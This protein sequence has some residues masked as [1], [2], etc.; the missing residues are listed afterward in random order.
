MA[1]STIN[2]AGLN[3]PLTLTSPVIDTITSAAA[4]ALTL[5]SAGTTAV[6]I[7]T[8]QNLLIGSTSTRASSKLDIRG[9]VMT[10]GSN[11]SYYAK[12]DYSAGTGLL[13]LAAESGG[14]TRFLG[15]TTE[16]MRIGS[17]GQVSIGTN[18][19]TTGFGGQFT[20]LATSATGAWNAI[21]ALTSCGSYALVVANT[22][23]SAGNLVYFAYNGNNVGTIITNGS[24]TTYNTS[25]DY[26]LKENVAPMT[27]ALATVAKLKP[28]TYK[29]KINGTDGQGFIAHELQ[30]VIPEAVT[31]EKDA[32]ET[33]KDKN[34]NEKTRIK[35]QGVDTSYIVAT[36]TAAIQELKA[37]FDAY[38]ASHP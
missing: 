15:G 21:Q 32:M 1:I 16:W 26:R 22:N 36:L 35:P 33:Y 31:G 23:G 10:L 12:I 6:T 7:D 2:Q 28:C 18:T 29:W 19:H 27:G 14:G 5:K 8:S 17:S 37:E 13:S 4:T 20:V 3:A 24:N 9:D 38:K 25:S 30:A 11:A 34:G